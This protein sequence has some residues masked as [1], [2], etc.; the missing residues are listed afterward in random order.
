MLPWGYYM[1]CSRL[2]MYAYSS[3][4]QLCPLHED[5][6]LNIGVTLAVP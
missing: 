3:E 6:A 1:Q 4:Q 2:H 5:G